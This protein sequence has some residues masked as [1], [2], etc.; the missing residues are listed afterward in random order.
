[1]LKKIVITAIVLAFSQH[2]TAN[3][4]PN[5]LNTARLAGKTLL[6]QNA[7]IC[8]PPSSRSYKRH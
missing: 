3:L 5:E 1:M 2:A 6:S 7:K 4:T 8:H